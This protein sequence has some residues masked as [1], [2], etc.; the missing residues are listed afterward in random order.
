MISSVFSVANLSRCLAAPLFVC[1]LS[2]LAAQA[3]GLGDFFNRL[4]IP[5][6]TQGGSGN[7]VAALRDPETYLGVALASI[8][9]KD[10]P[11]RLDPTRLYPSVLELPGAPFHPTALALSATGL[12]APLPPGDYSLSV[13]AFSLAPS[14]PRPVPG[15]VYQLGPLEGRSADALGQVLWKGSLARVP[16]WQLQQT[17]VAILSDTPYPGMPE[18][19]RRTLD[20]F[21]PQLR[22]TLDGGMVVKLTQ[23]YQSIQAVSGGRLPPLPAALAKLGPR[24]IQALNTMRMQTDM[25]Q[26]AQRRAQ[27]V[28]AA[29]PGGI[30]NGV[31]SGEAHWT[32]T[33][34]GAYIRL[35]VTGGSQALNELQVRV[36]EAAAVTPASLFGARLGADGKLSVAGLVAYPVA[37]SGQ[38]LNLYPLATAQ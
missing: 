23:Q 9:D 20:G 18:D 26:D 11:V 29:F 5:G 10:L 2:P 38:V 15:A 28:F 30:E 22:G 35:R 31:A 7:P 17:A 4:P 6:L 33:T 21:I 34:S 19:T 27:T 24:G 3:S 25:A 32:Q 8:V 13:L 16:T 12:Y 1:G 14:A 37:V 36:P